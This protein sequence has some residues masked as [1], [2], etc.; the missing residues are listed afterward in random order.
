[1]AAPSAKVSVV[2]SQAVATSAQLRARFEAFWERFPY[3]HL[4]V[5]GLR[6]RYLDTGGDARPPLLLHGHLLSGGPVG[7]SRGTVGC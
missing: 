2:A 7:R 3:R 5:D 4:Q 6:W 1:M